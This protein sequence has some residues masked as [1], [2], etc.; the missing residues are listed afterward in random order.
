MPIGR[1]N[2]KLGGVN[3]VPMS[4][5]LMKLASKPYIIMGDF[6]TVTLV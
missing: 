1:I 5:M 3:A 4:G 2:A 6:S